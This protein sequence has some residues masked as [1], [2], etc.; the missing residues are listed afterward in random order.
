MNAVLDQF[1]G[2]AA[3]LERNRLYG[4]YPAVVVDIKDPDGQGRVKIKLPWAPDMGGGSYQVWARLAVLMAGNNRGT[5]IIPDPNDEVLVFFEGGDPRRPYVVGMLWNGQDTPPESMDGNGNNFKKTIRSR[6][7]VKITIDDSDGSE[8]IT[9]ETPGGQ[10][11][12]LK[13]GPGTIELQDSNG[14][15][16]KTDPSGITVRAAADLT[17][18]C[19]GS[20]TVNGLSV[21]V[22]A[23]QATFSGIVQAN[24][25]ITPSV[26]GGSYTP[27]MGNIW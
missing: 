9:L 3:A 27:G 25:F 15:D 7:G 16:I 12:T 17:V 21:T 6:N 19:G 24:A 13:D 23:A 11:A 14:N 22:N 8:S 18:Q 2:F 26:V 1:D 20:V 5:W 10:K 4:A